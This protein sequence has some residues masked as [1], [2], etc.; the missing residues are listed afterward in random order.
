M[1]STML[2]LAHDPDILIDVA[3]AARQAGFQ[4]APGR[5][6]EHGT[7]ALARVQASVALVHIMHE[8]AESIAFGAL[9]LQ[10]GTTVLL[11][12]TRD[13]PPIERARVSIIGGASSA[14]IL[15]Y[16]GNAAELVQEVEKRMKAAG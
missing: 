7:D 2:L 5:Y 3:T 8:A 14:P 13:G 16:R 10:Q 15:E 4:V 12:A 6:Q 9:A 11:F 1:R